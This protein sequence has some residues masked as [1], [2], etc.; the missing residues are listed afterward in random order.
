MTLEPVTVHDDWLRLRFPDGAH[1]DFHHRW[2]RH[3]C[4]RDRHPATR[5]R[6]LCSSELPDDLRPDAAVVRGDALDLRWPDG[7]VTE[8]RLAW[9]RAHAY[10]LGRAAPSPPVHDPELL[11][12]RPGGAPLADTAAA[13]LR[14]I[15]ARGA[16][17]VRVAPGAGAPEDA[18]EPL[19]AAFEALGLRTI[20][21]HFG[22]VE[23]LR[24]D[25]T[26]NHNTDQLGYTDAPVHLHT[27]QPFLDAPPRYQLLQCIRP[28]AEGG[29]N[30]LADARA[31]YRVLAAEDARAADLLA[32]VPVT[33]HRKQKQFERIVVSP[34]VA[35]AGDDDFLIRSSYFTVAPHALPF[36]AMAEFYRA[37]DRFVRYVRDPRHHVRA[38]LGPGDWLIYDNHRTLHA[39][40]G[41]RGAR[42][43]RGVY[44]DVA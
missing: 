9:L 13:A 29:D 6:T 38:R 41:F 24:T 1:A 14:S 11:T 28:A 21:T 39:R 34:I 23:D 37:H 22:R 17:I 35:R 10:A 27:D 25:N 18:T 15:H 32:R 19:I 5:E 43:L 7:H 40:T 2:L 42:W 33:F 16:A 20:A 44:F 30:M 3:N 26:T 4:D 31:A 12:L 8:Y 36:A